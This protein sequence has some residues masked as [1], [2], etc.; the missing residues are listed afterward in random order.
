MKKYSYNTG[1]PIEKFVVPTLAETIT[2]FD[3]IR[4]GGKIFRVDFI[5]R[6]T[7]EKR[8]MICRCGVKK[9]LKGGKAAYSF[10]EKGLLAVYDY[11][12]HGYRSI[13]IDNVNMIKLAGV[14]YWLNTGMHPGEYPTD[15][16]QEICD[17]RSIPAWTSPLHFN[18]GNEVDHHQW[19]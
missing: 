7:G 3:K 19:N 4:F 16:F 9:Y 6:T 14:V 12:R 5:K 17:G 10:S 11:N 15:V 8:T 13:P 18:Q 1:R 2:L